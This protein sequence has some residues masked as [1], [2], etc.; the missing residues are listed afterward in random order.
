[1][2]GIDSIAMRSPKLD[3]TDARRVWGR[4]R[5][6]GAPTGAAASNPA[7]LVRPR[8]RILPWHL[9]PAVASLNR[10]TLREP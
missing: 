6:N 8:P 10:A 9:S 2:I 7:W 4:L 3:A 1:M 5:G